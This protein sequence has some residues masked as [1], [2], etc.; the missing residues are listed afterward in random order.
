MPGA[1]PAAVASAALLVALAATAS[2]G[3]SGDPA[4]WEHQEQSSTG[5]YSAVRTVKVDVDSGNVVVHHGKA[6]RVTSTSTWFMT[7]PTVTVTLRNGVLTVTGRCPRLVNSSLV[8][9][10][11]LFG[12]CR[13]DIDVS[14]SSPPHALTAG[15]GF[16]DVTV[17]G[18]RGPSRLSS[19]LGDVTAR[20]LR[21]GAVSVS[22]GGGDADLSEVTAAGLRTSSGSGN[23]RLSRVRSSRGISV[24]TSGGTVSVVA[25]IAP[26]AQVSTGNAQAQLVNV[27]VGSLGIHTDGSP[28]ILSD[29]R[30]R[31]AALSSGAG[32]AQ[33][34]AVQ[35]SSGLTVET[36]GGAVQV[37][38]VRAP[39]ISVASSQGATT[40][41]RSFLGTVSVRTDGGPL[42]L[43]GTSFRTLD[44]DARTGGVSM[45]V[46][47]VFSRLAVSTSDADMTLTVP[48]GPYV[49]DLR[50]TGKV[51]LLGVR[52]DPGAASTIAV[53]SGT[54]DI[55]LHG[56]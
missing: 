32:Q 15:T 33:L 25:L 31:T 40:L 10:G 23:T 48:A 45:T 34:N 29:S 39:R 1:Y 28:A 56:R 21:G 37:D 4:P 54:G 50:N 53:S 30:V 51:S 46:P 26:S 19:G 17:A 35:A 9:A 52:P 36:G 20:D 41:S 55:T 18:V 14:L 24:S 2:A 8:S 22:T 44:A 6:S 5:L 38:Q 27:R 42:Q 12:S 43:S 16:G 13:T 47:A 49:L 7:K 3:T 11:D